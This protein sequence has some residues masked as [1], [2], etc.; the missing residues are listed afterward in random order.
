MRTPTWMILRGLL[1]FS[2]FSLMLYVAYRYLVGGPPDAGSVYAVIFPGSILLGGTGLALAVKPFALMKIRSAV[3][4]RV[5]LVALGLVWMGTGLLCFQS[6]AAGTVAAP[7]GGTL[8]LF[9]MLT[10]H[11]VVPTGLFFLAGIPG[12]VEERLEGRRPEKRSTRADWP[13]TGQARR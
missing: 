8:T 9:H 5:A 2:G 11:V 10:H 7:I 3:P 13:R 6:L 4:L 1:A 12:W